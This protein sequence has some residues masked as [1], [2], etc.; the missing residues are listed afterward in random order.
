MDVFKTRI[1]VGYETLFDK[2]TPKI[3]EMNI[4]RYTCEAECYVGT[5]IDEAEKCAEICREPIVRFN[6][7]W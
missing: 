3:R 4:G 1:R 2:V 7:V 5:N 6:D